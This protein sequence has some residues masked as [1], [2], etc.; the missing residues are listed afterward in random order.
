MALTDISGIGSKTAEKLREQGITT[1]DQ[2][3]RE[4]ENRNPDVV[5]G[6]GKS[7]LNS[8]AI[9][10]I[11]DELLNQGESF[12]DPVLNIDVG[13]DNQKAVE[14][15]G[16]KTLGDL[17]SVDVTQANSQSERV[18]TADTTLASLA[19]PAKEGK[20]GPQNAPQSVIGWASDAAANL[21]DTELDSGQMQDV[22]TIKRDSRGFQ[23]TAPSETGLGNDPL[24]D[25]ATEQYDLDAREVARAESFHED[26][27]EKAQ[28][29][30]ER[31][32]A[33]VTDEITKWRSNPDHWDY[34]GVDT[35]AQMG[36]FFADKRKRK[37]GGFGSYSKENRDKKRLMS[38]LERI[39]NVDEEVQEQAIGEPVA[40]DIDRLF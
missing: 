35:P 11:R 8:R 33:P 39:Q 34:P 40:F 38:E 22:N 25:S 7:G 6:P 10:G 3:L 9:S 27:P 20:L 18:L 37:R 1:K 29:V 2:L 32:D 13:P 12:F 21:T 23:T 14:T 26:R 17:P 15:I 36:E 30:D 19:E 31:R 16:T 24:P 4:F 5:G 28:R